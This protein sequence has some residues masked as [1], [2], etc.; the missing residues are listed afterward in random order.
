MV[1]ALAGAVSWP[2]MMASSHS[3]FG[4]VLILIAVVL[5]ARLLFSMSRGHVRVDGKVIV[6]CSQGHVF[7]TSWSVLG[8]FTAIRLGSARYQ[9]CPVGNHW[10]IVRPVTEDNLTD[11]ERRTV[12]LD[13]NTSS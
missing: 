9:R 4:L 12:G 11:E 13:G 1:H 7:P 5:V 2:S 10:S 6:R 3:S 8:S